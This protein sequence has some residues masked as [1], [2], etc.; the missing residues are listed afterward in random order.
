MP[1]PLHAFV[2]KYMVDRYSP[3][4]ALQPLSR[5]SP[6]LPRQPGPGCPPVPHHALRRDAQDLGRFFHAEAAEVTQLDDAGAARIDS[7]QRIERLVEGADVVGRPIVSGCARG[8]FKDEMARG[9]GGQPTTD[10]FVMRADGSDVRRLTDDA[11]EEG[12]VAFALEV[13]AVNLT[14]VRGRPL[15]PSAQ[16]EYLSPLRF[17]P[18]HEST[19][20]RS[21]VPSLASNATAAVLHGRMRRGRVG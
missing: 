19:A 11:A 17:G 21:A 14:A 20:R 4:R 3:I 13:K 5:L 1:Q 16:Q 12:T 15:S 8:G 6:E 9:G 2:T 18:V 10:I 7:R